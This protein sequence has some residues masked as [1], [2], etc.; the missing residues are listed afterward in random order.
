M[1]KEREIVFNNNKGFSIV[2][3]LV[4]VAFVS[5]L[6]SI[7]LF[8]SLTNYQ[9]KNI[10]RKNKQT[11][12]NAE[13]VLNEVRV[14]LQQVES[15]SISQAY[16]NVLINYNTAVDTENAF[17]NNFKDALCEWEKDGT[18][19][20]STNGAGEL[21]YNPN[22]LLTFVNDSTGV[23]LEGSQVEVT[24]DFVKLK[25]VSV[26]Y[27]KNGY[28]THVA[29]DICMAV[30]E[31]TYTQSEMVLSAVPDYS[32]IADVELKQVAGGNIVVDGNAYAGK[33]SIEGAG[34]RM[35]VGVGDNFICNGTLSTNLAEFYMGNTSSL[36]AK[37]IELGNLGKVSA[38]GSTYVAD[39]IE[40]LGD[41][42]G[43]VLKGKYF[44]FGKSVTNAAQSSSIIVNGKDT[45][46]D[47]SGLKNLMLAGNSF[48]GGDDNEILMGE[49]L[50]VKSNQLAYLI[51]AEF[52][53]GMATNPII[54]NNGDPLLSNTAALKAYVNKDAELWDG[55]TISTYTNDVQLVFH[56][57]GASQTLVYYYMKFDTTEKA[58]Q[59]FADYFQHNSTEIKK[60]LEI[61][62]ESIAVDNTTV[63]N[64]SGDIVSYDETGVNLIN[65][66]PAVSATTSQKLAAMFANLCATLSTNISGEGTVY[67][68]V[69]DEDAIAAL[70]SDETEFKTGED[71]MAVVKKG[72]YTISSATPDTLKI[73]VATGDVEVNSAFTGLIISGGTVNVMA[74]L[75]ADREG[76]SQAF[77]A[78]ATIGADEKRIVDF[79]K[80][81]SEDDAGTG[82]HS[83]NNWNLDKLVTYKN[84]IKD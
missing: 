28:E 24:E 41:E 42:S 1:E 39:D 11:F 17:Q 72:D 37:R 12:Y 73:I 45:T 50:S 76:V 58:S 3:V 20:L 52:I 75:Q 70:S 25:N 33:I 38:L 43:V 56:P 46:L 71:V 82:A 59:Y 48:I 64:I 9:M 68:Y 49:S 54:F 83:E 65:A 8:T 5:I 44:G 62:S 30:P 69:V 81:T 10:E 78:K 29:A 27:I 15:D 31:F 23:V 66:S 57:L 74:N 80:I 40:L 32:L 67:N 63:K 55:K 18:L 61:Y 19:L 26:S 51:P 4:T 14:G 13:S 7:L 21:I 60:Y 79:L 84:W 77:A 35:E 22:V 36:W 34:N 47:I 53:E 6:G 16:T 2:A